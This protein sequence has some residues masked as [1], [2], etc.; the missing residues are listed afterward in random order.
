MHPSP[1]NLISLFF[2][3]TTP[4]VIFG[5]GGPRAAMRA[6]LVPITTP[7]L[8]HFIPCPGGKNVVLARRHL[9]TKMI[10]GWVGK[11]PRRAA[12]FYKF[13]KY[14]GISCFFT[15]FAEPGLSR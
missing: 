3:I 11:E 7:E 12:I 14:N 8:L 6:S 5:L 13:D 15:H 1:S 9:P 4:E 10:S 2:L